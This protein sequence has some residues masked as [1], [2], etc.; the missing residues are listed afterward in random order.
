MH[1]FTSIMCALFGVGLMQSNRIARRRHTVAAFAIEDRVDFRFIDLAEEGVAEVILNPPTLVSGR[2]SIAK[3]PNANG[4]RRD[5][6]FS[7]R[8]PVEGR[9]YHEEV[10]GLMQEALTELH[11]HYANS[12][13][14]P[15]ED[16][17]C[18][19]VSVA[20][21]VRGAS[22]LIQLPLWDWPTQPEIVWQGPDGT[23]RVH[24]SL[25]EVIEE[26]CT[27]II[28]AEA[29]QSLP[30]DVN[31]NFIAVND[32]VAAAAATVCMPEAELGGATRIALVRV[33]NGVNSAFIADRRFSTRASH[34]ETGHIYP[35]LH[36]I[37]ID[38]G[39]RGVCPF[40]GSCL[41]G[42]IGEK[43]ILERAFPSDPN[44]TP[45]PEWREIYLR[46]I[47]DGVGDVARALFNS[48]IGD[49]K[50]SKE[51][52]G[53]DIYSHYISQIVH[54]MALSAMV[55]DRILL[56]GRFCTSPVIEKTKEKLKN[57]TNGYPLSDALRTDN[58]E[59]IIVSVP[60]KNR[61]YIDLTGSLAIAYS[62]SID[63]DPKEG[64][65]VRKKAFRRLFDTSVFLDI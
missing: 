22:I 35:A 23:R 34:P 58:I 50:S 65:F 64:R 5:Y 21:V 33:H 9:G 11:A 37:D 45:I 46:L 47:K 27:G 32:A 28:G 25:T 62:K 55:P 51:S 13:R 38:N 59:N 15:L 40:H 36:D 1:D 48:V 60:R 42:M 17:E 4:G 24:F 18:L 57:L 20:G 19:G 53:V 16:I 14:S 49:D 43:S 8:I 44:V 29:A 41:E 2:H 63:N 3:S 54:Q 31:V 39:F 52:L 7:R 30:T 10:Y 56:T 12:G 61:R 26:I 6:F